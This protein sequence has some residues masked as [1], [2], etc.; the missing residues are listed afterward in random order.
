MSSSVSVE[1]PGRAPSVATSRSVEGVGGTQR[2]R[3]DVRTLVSALPLQ[4]KPPYQGEKR[5]T[6]TRSISA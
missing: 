6:P 2:W 3:L 1:A 4:A 5:Q